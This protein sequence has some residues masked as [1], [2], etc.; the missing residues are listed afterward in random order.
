[1][2]KK[3]YF[4]V[5][6]S[7]QQ[8][9]L[10]NQRLEDFKLFARLATDDVLTL[11]AT[12]KPGNLKRLDRFSY[13]IKM[14][15]ITKRPMFKCKIECRFDEGTSTRFGFGYRQTQDLSDGFHLVSILIFGFHVTTSSTNILSTL[16]ATL[17]DRFVKDINCVI[18]IEKYNIL[19]YI[20]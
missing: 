3:H 18:I 9:N 5:F 13:Q 6:L 2:T 14:L 17:C 12:W 15:C 19:T 16:E 11:G 8:T 20:I 1:M 7:L 4:K 10:E